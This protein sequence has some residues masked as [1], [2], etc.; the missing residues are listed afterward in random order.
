M[1][2]R[3]TSPK[4]KS[5]FHCLGYIN[6]KLG[7]QDKSVAGLRMSSLPRSGMLDYDSDRAADPL[8]S[9]ESQ[10]D[11]LSTWDW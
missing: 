7:A 5:R 1:P 8:N 6:R 9:S 11:L 4:L 10:P 3:G 2:T